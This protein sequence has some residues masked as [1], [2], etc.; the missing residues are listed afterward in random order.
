M[1]LTP[2]LWI[3]IHWNSETAKTLSKTHQIIAKACVPHRNFLNKHQLINTPTEIVLYQMSK[4]MMT[5]HTE[6][7]S[8][9]KT[10]K[11]TLVLVLVVHHFPTINMLLMYDK[12]KHINL[13]GLICQTWS[14]ESISCCPQQAV[15]FQLQFSQTR[16]HNESL[17]PT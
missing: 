8:I 14:K 3:A 17:K 1:L 7:H 11:N 6:Q 2:I 13:L 4:Q 12:A 9:T 5:C 15:T 16:P 10:Q